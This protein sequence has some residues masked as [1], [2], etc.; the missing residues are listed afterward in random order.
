MPAPLQTGTFLISSIGLEDPTFTRTVILL[1]KHHPEEVTLG[2]IINRPL[3]EH[4][5]MYPTDELKNLA[6]GLES[7][8]QSSCMFYRGGPVEPSSLIFLHRIISASEDSTCIVEGLYAGGDLDLLRT[9]MAVIDDNIP[10]LRFYLGFANWAPGQLENEISVGAWILCPANVDLVFSEEPD[11]VWQKA[12][13][14]LGG[15]YAPMS[16]IPEDPRL[17]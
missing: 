3:G 15:K 14:S 13:H 9:N 10:L 8:R 17:N 1:L 7:G 12:L 11:I 2:V 16:F 4:L 6:N 5:K